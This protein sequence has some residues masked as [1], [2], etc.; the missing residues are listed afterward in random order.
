MVR[1]ILTEGGKNNYVYIMNI[2]DIE[3][4]GAIQFHSY[5]VTNGEYH[6]Y[7]RLGLLVFICK[8]YYVIKGDVD[9]VI[10]SYHKSR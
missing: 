2:A 8:S 4:I 5:E 1:F 3:S 9:E 6:F 10:N 7:N